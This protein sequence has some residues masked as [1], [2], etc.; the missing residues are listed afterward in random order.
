MVVTVIATGY[1][2]K[3][4]ES[5][6][7]IFDEVLNNKSN[8]QLEMTQ[9]GLKSVDQQE[10]KKEGPKIPSWLKKKGSL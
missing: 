7:D 4:T 10:D 8:H 9:S 6:L 2:L 3:G 1:E 5:G